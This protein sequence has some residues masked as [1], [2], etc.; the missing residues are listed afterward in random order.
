MSSRPAPVGVPA[1]EPESLVVVS[2]EPWDE[3][4][5][6]N[7]YLVSELLRAD[8]TLHVLFVEPPSDL[9]YAALRRTTPGLVGV[10]GRALSSTASGPTG[11][12]CTSPPRR[13]HAGSPTG[14]TST[15]R[16]ASCARPATRASSGRRCGS[17]TPAWR[18]CSTPASRSC[19]T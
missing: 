15:A 7:Q 9:A 11:S 18:R 10:C 13:C 6:R 16:A 1:G 8:P 14:T 19:T 17:T 3:V 4:W 2:L 5:R 12:G